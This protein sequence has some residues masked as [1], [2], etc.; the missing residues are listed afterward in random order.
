MKRKHFS[1]DSK[2]AAVAVYREVKRFRTEAPGESPSSLSLARVA[3]GGASRTQ[4]YAWLGE[5]LSIE[6]DTPHVERRGV[7]PKLSDDQQHLLIGFAVSE[8]SS[9]QPVSLQTL[10]QFTFTHLEVKLSKSTLSQLMTEYGFSSQKVL[11]RNSRMVSEAVVEDA[12][13]FIAEIRSYGYPPH[14]VIAMDETGLWSNVTA[15]KTYHFK[16]W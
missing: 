13:S 6:D 9:L 2:R 7:H 15:P 10:E 8:R 14:R 4:I 11:A 16:N 1:E 12:L 3:S 5:E